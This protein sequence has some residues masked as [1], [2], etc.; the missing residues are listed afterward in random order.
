MA[1]DSKS[2]ISGQVPKLAAIQTSLSAMAA[3]W[4]GLDVHNEN[5]L[6]RLAEMVKE[7]EAGIKQRELFFASVPK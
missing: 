2:I 5:E 3:E 1:Q 7:L 6:L 4:S